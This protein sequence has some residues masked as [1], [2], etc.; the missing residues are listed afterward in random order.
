MFCIMHVRGRVQTT[1]VKNNLKMTF[2]G[3]GVKTRDVSRLLTGH[4]LQARG[5]Q[6]TLWG[7]GGV[8]YNVKMALFSEKI[9]WTSSLSFK[10]TGA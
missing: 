7:G 1:F 10:K 4:L 5:R 6:V 9:V 8:K 2:R 3:W